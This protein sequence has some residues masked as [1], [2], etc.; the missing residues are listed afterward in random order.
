MQAV[1]PF[2]TLWVHPLIQVI[3]GKVPHLSTAPTTGFTSDLLLKQTCNSPQNKL[4]PHPVLL[5]LQFVYSPFYS[6]Q[7]ILN[8]CDYIWYFFKLV[9][10]IF[11]ILHHLYHFFPGETWWIRVLSSLGWLLSVSFPENGLNIGWFAQLQY[12]CGCYYKRISCEIR[13]YPL[14]RIIGFKQLK[15]QTNFF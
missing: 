5:V 13:R 4:L 8:P 10:N 12:W 2:C 7:M 6:N 1:S 15:V 3:S 11:I 14:L 9:Y